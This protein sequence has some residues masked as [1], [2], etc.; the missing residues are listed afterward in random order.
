M[1][2]DWRCLGKLFNARVTL[3]NVFVLLWLR[4]SYWKGSYVMQITYTHSTLCCV[5]ICSLLSESAVNATEY[6]VSTG[7]CGS[8]TT[9]CR[10]ARD[11]EKSRERPYGFFYE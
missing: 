5:S 10:A 11:V 9:G 6:M 3:L 7:I 1:G 4:V 2:K 8:N